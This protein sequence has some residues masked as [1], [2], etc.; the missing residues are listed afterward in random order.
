MLFCINQT[1]IFIANIVLYRF[2]FVIKS[3]CMG[4]TNVYFLYLCIFYQKCTFLSDNVEII[5][6][7]ILML[8][9]I[10]VFRL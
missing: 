3:Y 9:A 8:F 4:I 2:D 5:D 10:R 7:N 6:I 1:F